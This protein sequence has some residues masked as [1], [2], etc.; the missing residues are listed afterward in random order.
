MSPRS[1]RILT[2]AVFAVL[3][4]VGMLWRSPLIELQT[5]ITAVAVG[6]VVACLVYWLLHWFCGRS[7]G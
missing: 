6:L 2:A 5:V 7:H 1:N 4:I 3:W